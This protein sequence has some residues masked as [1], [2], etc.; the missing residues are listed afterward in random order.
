ME[1]LG[2][3]CHRDVFTSECP[4]RQHLLRIHGSIRYIFEG[5]NS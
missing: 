1:S 4:T 2:T 5:V 3:I